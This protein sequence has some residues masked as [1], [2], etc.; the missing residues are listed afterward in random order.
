LCVKFPKNMI[1]YI[2]ILIPSVN[3]NS[4]VYLIIFKSQNLFQLCLSLIYIA[5]RIFLIIMTDVIM[6]NNMIYVTI[7]VYL[8]LILF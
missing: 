8:Q 3:H 5:E 4:I 7:T 1:S 6:I 2:Y